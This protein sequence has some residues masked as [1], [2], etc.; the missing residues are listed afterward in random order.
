MV[1]N[2]DYQEPKIYILCKRLWTFWN[3]NY[4]GAHCMWL[5]VSNS[6]VFSAY[7]SQWYLLKK[8]DTPLVTLLN[9]IKSRIKRITKIWELLPKKS[10]V[11]TSEQHWRTGPWPGRCSQKPTEVL[12]WLFTISRHR[13]SFQ[14]KITNG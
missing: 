10:W 5:N 1:S 13:V 3:I 12:L 4:H 2:E 7:I 6:G 14:V 8:Y 11:I 9:I